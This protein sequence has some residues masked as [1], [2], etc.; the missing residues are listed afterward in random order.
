ARRGAIARLRGR[1]WPRPR[2]G[3]AGA[4][5]A[6]ARRPCRACD[7]R[8]RRA[9]RG[10]A[11]GGCGR[12]ALAGAYGDRR[13]RRRRRHRRPRGGDVRPSRHERRRRLGHRLRRRGRSWRRQA[14]GA[15]A[16]P[17]ALRRGARGRRG[18]G[19]R[20]SARAT[21]AEG[22]L[23]PFPLEATTDES[24]RARLGPIAPGGAT[25]SAR[26][27]GFVAR[28]T[29]VVPD[30]PPAELRVA[31]ARA[32][33]MTGR[34]VDVHGQPID[35][36]TL[37]IVGTDLAG[38][39]I[40][41]DPQRTVFQAAHFDAMLAGPSPLLPAGGLGVVAGPVPPIPGGNASG[42]RAAA[43]GL[44]SAFA[45]AA[46]GMQAAQVAAPWV[47]GADGTFRASPASPGRVGVVVRH[48]QYVEAQSELVTL[49]PGGEAHVEVGMHEGGALEGRVVDARGR[50]IESARVV[51]SATRGSLERSTRTASDGS[52][53]FVALPEA[54][55]VSASA[56]DGDTPDVRTTVAVPEGGRKE[57]TIALP[58]ARDALPVAVVDASGWPVEAA[59][60]SASSLSPESVLRT[61]AFTDGHG[62]ASLR[63]ARGLP[64]RVE[65]RA[66]SHAPRVVTADGSEE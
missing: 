6:E 64:L 57:L 20:R 66:P 3:P 1:H 53:V 36:A 16:R 43:P 54:V 49:A 52:F 10:S 24:G 34:V 46:P 51:V 48:P 29:V 18:R 33:A 39:P 59:Q 56:S 13:R 41:D 50:P 19:R 32:G 65:V 31:L 58:E 8:G 9:R 37:E 30:P 63:R 45:R 14:G 4:R 42:A 25:L 17:R 11:R 47:T 26:A 44:P 12:D 15:P 22:G 61:T 55:L 40:F 5:P 35:G 2:G 23:S 21:G 7:R 62:D 60:V 28:G 38:Q 27:D